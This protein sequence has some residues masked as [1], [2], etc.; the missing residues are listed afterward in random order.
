VIASDAGGTPL[1][2]ETLPKKLGNVNKAPRRPVWPSKARKASLAVVVRQTRVGGLRRARRGLSW[3]SWPSCHPWPPREH[4]DGLHRI[5]MCGQCTSKN[6]AK[7]ASLAKPGEQDRERSERAKTNGGASKATASAGACEVGN[8]SKAPCLRARWRETAKR[9]KRTK[10]AE[11]SARRAASKASSEAGREGAGGANE[12][13]SAA[14][15]NRK[16]REANEV[17]R[18][19]PRA[20]RAG[21]ETTKRSK[22]VRRNSRSHVYAKELR[23]SS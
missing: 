4:A 19:R 8:E 14:N 7:R 11:P 5:V 23:R 22:I 6:E 10:S 18:T 16:T 12:V 3:V 9:A 13:R 20:E 15:K 17:R 2:S 1:T 21:V